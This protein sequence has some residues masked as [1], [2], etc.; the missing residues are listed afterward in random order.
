[1]NKRISFKGLFLLAFSAATLMGHAQT[2]AKIDSSYANWYYQA[3]YDLFQQL[4]G[5]KVDIVFLGNSITE[6]G[7]WLELLPGKRVANRGIGGDNSFGV[8]ARLDGLIAQQPSRVFLMIGINDLGRGLP[9]EVIVNNYRRILHRLGTGLPGA[10]VYLQS[11][12]PLNE[13]LLKYDYLKGKNQRVKQLNGELVKLAAEYGHTFVNL[14]EVMAGADGELNKEFTM[15]G[16]HLKTDA[17]L[18]WVEYLK[19]KNY[20]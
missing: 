14:H 8:L 18:V 13:S 16:I 19:K 2:A 5:K 7:D 15:D 9:V 17:Y 4:T 11:V 12:L 3:R 20:L 1:M 6:R 10:K